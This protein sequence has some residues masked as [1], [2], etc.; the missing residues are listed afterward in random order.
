MASFSCGSPLHLDMWHLL[1]HCQCHGDISRCFQHHHI[2][3]TSM[4]WRFKASYK[5]WF[6]DDTPF[7]QVW[8]QQKGA[9]PLFFSTIL[10]LYFLFHDFHI[11]L[12]GQFVMQIIKNLNHLIHHNVNSDG[13]IHLFI[14]FTITEGALHT[15]YH[16]CGYFYIRKKP[17]FYCVDLV[18]IFWWSFTLMWSAYSLQQ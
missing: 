7:Q 15:F 17:T 1:S 5:A 16:T 11:N 13:Q 4:H 2:L 3:F 18:E 6:W 10:W 9:N 8:N 14:G 12:Q